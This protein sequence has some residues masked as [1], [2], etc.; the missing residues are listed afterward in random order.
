MK[1]CYIFIASVVILGLVVPN[2][3]MAQVNRRDFVGLWQA[4]DSLDGSTQ[5]LSITCT[6]KQ[7][8]DVR[9]N[10]TAFTNSCPDQIGFARGEGSIEGRELIVVLTLNCTTPA[11]PAAPLSQL[12]EFVLESNGTLTNINDDPGPVANVFHRISN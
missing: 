12:N 10:D 7:D 5:Y 6:S 4:I 3:T 2:V 8:C 9:L 11:A 1:H